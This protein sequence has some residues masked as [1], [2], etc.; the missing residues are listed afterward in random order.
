MS[1]APFEA[2]RWGKRSSEKLVRALRLALCGSEDKPCDVLSELAPFLQGAGDCD[3][4][5]E[6]LDV[7]FA[8]HSLRWAYSPAGPPPSTKKRIVLRVLCREGIPLDEDVLREVMGEERAEEA[9][10]A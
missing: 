6:A 1:L 4:L 10:T 3:E 7:Y 5:E 2:Y 8:W 9:E